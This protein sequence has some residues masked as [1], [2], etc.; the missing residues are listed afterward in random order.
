L[1]ATVELKADSLIFTAKRAFPSQLAEGTF[2]GQLAVYF[3]DANFLKYL[4]THEPLSVEIGVE[5][6]NA[7]VIEIKD[8][9][10]KYT[11]LRAKYQ[12]ER[13]IALNKNSKPTRLRVTGFLVGQEAGQEFTVGPITL[14][15]IKP[16]ILSAT[17]ATC[18][19]D[20]LAKLSSAVRAGR[21]P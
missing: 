11:T 18:C 9:Q 10:Q 7:G 21:A 14:G 2:Y 5:I 17:T 8:I 6:P 20:D 3:D 15:D 1:R 4:D 19:A 12:A 13:G 16:P